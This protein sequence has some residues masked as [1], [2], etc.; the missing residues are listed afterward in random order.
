VALLAAAAVAL[1]CGRQMAHPYVTYFNPE[2]PL[3]LR[4]PS[5]WTSDQVEQEGASYRYFLAPRVGSARQPA[6]ST[7]LLVEPAGD[8]EQAAQR[9]VAGQNVTATRDASREGLPG[10]SWRFASPDGAR[11]YSLVLHTDRDRLLGLY[12]QA[13]A[14]R[15]EEHEAAIDEMEKSLAP[16]RPEVYPEHRSAKVGFSLRVPGSWKATRNFSS[17]TTH[18]MQFTSPALGAEEGQT[19]H[20]TLSLTGEPAA[21]GGLEGY[22][23]AVRSRLGE[24]FSPTRHEPWRDGY[25]DLERIETQVATS[26]AKRYFRVHGRRGYVLACEARDDVFHRVARWCDII[27]STLAV[28]PEVAPQ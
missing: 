1:G 21:A 18:L 28:G 11:R 12:T 17:D 24:A 10:K 20:A 25:A 5:N 3:T 14:A 13:E 19:V 22:Y 26:R 8:L 16:E 7:A 15:F 9:Y 2:P 4:L 27:A 6:V 23:Q